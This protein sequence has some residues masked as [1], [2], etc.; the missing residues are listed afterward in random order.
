MPKRVDSLGKGKSDDDESDEIKVTINSEMHLV[1]AEL[2]IDKPKETDHVKT[3]EAEPFVIIDQDQVAPH[4]VVEAENEKVESAKQK[5]AEGAEKDV[6]EKPTAT[7][8]HKA[9]EKPAVGELPVDA[10]VEHTPAEKE[11]PATEEAPTET[12]AVDETVTVEKTPVVKTPETEDLS[13]DKQ[14]LAKEAPANEISPAIV[15][16][17]EETAVTAAAAAVVTEAVASGVEETITIEK[18]IETAAI[19]VEEAVASASDVTATATSEEPSAEI[20]VEVS[21]LTTN[22]TTCSVVEKEITEIKINETGT[23]AEPEPVNETEKPYN[24]VWGTDAHIAYPPEPGPVIDDDAV[25]A[26]TPVT[27]TP[28]SPT[29]RPSISPKPTFTSAAKITVTTKAVETVPTNEQSKEEEAPETPTE[30]PSSGRF[31]KIKYKKSYRGFGIRI[32]VFVL[33]TMTT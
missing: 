28:K 18:T 8:E 14:A 11:P 15:V 22:V 20:T 13:T 17:A 10:P 2:N 4:K 33:T 31:T 12:T 1:H 24:I 19:V 32:L 7:G 23:A 6:T 26:S 16:A 25:F 5:N 21:K 9:E 30:C 3:T 29:D 27:S